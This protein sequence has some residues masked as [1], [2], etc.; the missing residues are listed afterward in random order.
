MIKLTK[1]DFE[2]V[3]DNEVYTSE[4]VNK[5]RSELQ[6]EELQFAGNDK[7]L[8]YKARLKYALSSHLPVLIRLKLICAKDGIDIFGEPLIDDNKLCIQPAHLDY[9][10]NLVNATFV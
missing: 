5:L 2:H 10:D 4:A 1:E 9:E 3:E 7:K 6:R 8:Q